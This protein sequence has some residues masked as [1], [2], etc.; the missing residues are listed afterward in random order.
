MNKC[1]CTDDILCKEAKRLWKRRNFAG[2]KLYSYHR[3]SMKAGLI[4]YTDIQYGQ[5]THEASKNIDR[6]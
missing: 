3:F 5:I 6:R 2:R 4:K 1:G